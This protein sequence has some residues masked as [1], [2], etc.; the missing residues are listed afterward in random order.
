MAGRIEV[1][2]VF[3]HLS[4]GALLA[5]VTG[6]YVLVVIEIVVI[7]LVEEGF[8]HIY[9]WI[10]LFCLKSKGLSETTAPYVGLTECLPHW[11]AL[12]FYSMEGARQ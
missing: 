4:L 8:G 11:C 9:V 1:V 10:Y 3:A 12:R 7:V 5:A 6:K 2:G